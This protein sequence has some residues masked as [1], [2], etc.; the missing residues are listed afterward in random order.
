MCRLWFNGFQCAQDSGLSSL[1][2]ALAGG[3]NSALFLDNKIYSHSN[4]FHMYK[5]SCNNQGKKPV[6]KLAEYICFMKMY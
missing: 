5:C 1:G 4:S 2:L 6:N 3:H